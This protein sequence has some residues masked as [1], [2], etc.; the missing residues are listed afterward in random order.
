MTTS[1]AGLT[2]KKTVRDH[3]HVFSHNL[4]STSDHIGG[5]L[6]IEPLATIDM[7]HAPASAKK[8]LDLR[9]QRIEQIQ[10]SARDILYIYTREMKKQRRKNEAKTRHLF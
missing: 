4:V 5:L 3:Q 8:N 10:T 7:A 1:L 2:C 6:Q 9:L